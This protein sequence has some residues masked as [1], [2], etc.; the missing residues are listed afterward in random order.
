[1]DDAME[2]C[3]LSV[4]LLV[5][6]LG[7]YLFQRTVE[8]RLFVDDLRIFDNIILHQADA[9]ND[10]H[11]R[12]VDTLGDA[13]RVYVTINE[14]DSVLKMSTIVNGR[15]LGNTAYNLN[16]ELPVYVDFSFGEDVRDQHRFF[17][18]DIDNEV[19]KTFIRRAFNGKRAETI[20]GLEFDFERNAYQLEFRPGEIGR[21]HV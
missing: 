19:I 5:H 4:N 11:E 15:R 16:G 1:M 10:G 7:N 20:S 8:E 21:A 13:K 17:R 2:G 3:R 14:E 12:W 6:S 18:P 9:D